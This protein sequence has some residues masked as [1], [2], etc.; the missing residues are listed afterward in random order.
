MYI[1]Y[2]RISH[3]G[4]VAFQVLNSQHSELTVQTKVRKKN[5]HGTATYN[6]K[7]RQK[8]FPKPETICKTH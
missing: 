3:F 4:L 1:S 6:K 7:K 5:I 2:L 8:M